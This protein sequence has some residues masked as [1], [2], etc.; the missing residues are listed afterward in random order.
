MVAHPFFGTLTLD[1]RLNWYEVE[2]PWCGRPIRV[3]FARDDCEEEVELFVT[4]QTLWDDQSGW[5][6]RVRNFASAELL[7]LKN[8]G[9]LQEGEEALTRVQFMDR[10]ALVAV[11]VCGDGMFEFTFKDGG[12][13][14]GHIIQ[15]SGT[16]AD[17]PKDAGIAG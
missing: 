10:M 1:R 12:M 7:E 17:G 6:A 3:S 4:A 14:G 8:D 2:F 9:W 5:D 16:L 15:V 13:F 11:V